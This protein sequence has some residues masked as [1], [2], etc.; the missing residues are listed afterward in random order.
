MENESFEESIIALVKE[1]KPNAT[2][3]EQNYIYGYTDAGMMS[4]LKYGNLAFLDMAYY[5]MVFGEDELLFL[6]VSMGG[7]LTG[8]YGNIPYSDIESF[9]VKK[10]MLQYVLTFKLVGENKTLKIKCN[11]KNACKAPLRARLLR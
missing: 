4:S 6:E 3:L 10:G 11:H 9:R 7:E 5:I 8:S 2:Q 1:I